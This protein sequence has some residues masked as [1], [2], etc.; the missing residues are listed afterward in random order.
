M[1]ASCVPCPDPGSVHA[2]QYNACVTCMWHQSGTSMAPSR[3]HR[4]CWE[5]WG[6][7]CRVNRWM[8][9]S[10]LRGSWICAIDARTRPGYRRAMGAVGWGVLPRSA[11]NNRMTQCSVLPQH[12]AVPAAEVSC[13]TWRS[14]QWL[15]CH[16]E[17]GGHRGR[18]HPTHGACSLSGRRPRST[19]CCDCQCL[20]RRDC[21][22]LGTAA[23]E[24]AV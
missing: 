21:G 22:G 17:P 4:R 18:P 2:L 10:W 24:A 6:R 12:G 3:L 16:T 20:Q 23:S 14:Q 11:F 7:T 1:H 8:R 9:S 15:R 19:R 13:R 5:L